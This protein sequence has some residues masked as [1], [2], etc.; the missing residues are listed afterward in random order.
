MSK[1]GHLQ[2]FRS[3]T[4]TITSYLERVEIYFTA[5]DVPEEKRVPVF[6]STVGATTYILLRDLVAP[7]KPQD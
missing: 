5:N 6:L 3:E 4:E 2:E 7:E 1:F